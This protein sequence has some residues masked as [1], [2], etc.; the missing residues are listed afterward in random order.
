MKIKLLAT[1]LVFT[2]VCVSAQVAVAVKAHGL[3]PAGKPTWESV[4]AGA[5]EAFEAE[6][7]T[8]VGFNAG[9]SVKVNLVSGLFV[10]PELYYTTFTNELTEPITDSKIEAK[11]NRADLPVLLGY[12]VWGE[13]VGI[14]AGPVASYNLSSENQYNDFK[15]NAENNFT[16]GYQ[17]GAQVKIK[18]IIISGRYEGSFSKDQREFINNN[19]DAVIR[20]DNRPSM[21]MAGLGYQF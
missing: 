2:S 8:N 10:M 1:A 20:Y 13:T 14:Y 6:G 7:K 11:S 12:N 18:S 16:V 19:T 3:F 4:K 9:L 5:E 21:L 15:E 17:L